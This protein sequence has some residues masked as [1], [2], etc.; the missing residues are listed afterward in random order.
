[1]WRFRRSARL[2]LS[3]QTAVL[4]FARAAKSNATA[5]TYRAPAA[6]PAASATAWWNSESFI[7]WLAQSAVRGHRLEI[8]LD[9]ALAHTSVVTRN[10]GVRNLRERLA[11]AGVSL[12]TALGIPL[13]HYTVRADD[14]IFSPHFLAAAIPNDFVSTL[15]ATCEAAGAVAGAVTTAF[16]AA[17]RCHAGA[18]PENTHWRVHCNPAST[19]IATLQS[20]RPTRVRLLR[21]VPATLAELD[22]L[23]QR[24]ILASAGTDGGTQVAVTGAAPFTASV[25]SAGAQRYVRVDAGG[26]LTGK[27]RFGATIRA[28][29]QTSPGSLNFGSQLVLTRP[30]AALLLAGVIAAGAVASQFWQQSETLN[31]ARQSLQA[32]EQRLAS[33]RGIVTSSAAQPALPAAQIKAV[34]E[35]VRRLNVPWGEIAQGIEAIRVPDT[36]LLSIEP[37][38]RSG[39]MVVLA[40]AKNA[41]AMLALYQRAL[42]DSQFADA[43][44]RKLE[45]NDKE[46]LPVL[47]FSLDARW[48]ANMKSAQP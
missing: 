5:L 17:V 43:H 7:A 2:Q 8:E 3:L 34:N 11:Y 20:G 37:N 26:V 40:E 13:D 6:T 42:N 47:R 36:A 31:A 9:D 27:S 30:A 16:A 46:A 14:D 39:R 19:V 29:I 1:M 21:A 12:E 44:L 24:E 18:V 28:L 23:L 41:D 25:D 4:S 22:A 45:P 48:N 32:A 38:A 15:T 10:A 33:A 35:A